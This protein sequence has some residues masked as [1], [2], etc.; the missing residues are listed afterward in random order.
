MNNNTTLPQSSVAKLY[1][2]HSIKQEGAKNEVRKENKVATTP[3][4]VP[5]PYQYVSRSYYYDSIG[6]GYQGL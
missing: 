1:V 2:A 6:G 3:V 5:Q 4:P